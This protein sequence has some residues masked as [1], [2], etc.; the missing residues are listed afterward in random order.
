MGNIYKKFPLTFYKNFVSVITW[1]YTTIPN[2]I[3]VGNCFELSTHNANQ[4]E[5]RGSKTDSNQLKKA[6]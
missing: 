4:N 1:S 2:S 3:A 6:K 5:I